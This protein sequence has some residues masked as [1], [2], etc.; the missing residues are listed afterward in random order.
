MAA[1]QASVT[2]LGD[3]LEN[4]M[5]DGVTPEDQMLVALGLGETVFTAEI[6]MENAGFKSTNRFGIY[7]YANPAAKLE[8]FAGADAV[9]DSVTV[10]F[11]AANDQ[12]WID[13]AE[14]MT[15]GTTFG[16]Y[17]DSSAKSQ[18]GVFYSDPMQNTG[19]DQGVVHALFFTPN[20]GELFVAFEDLR[21][22]TDWY[23]QDYNDM[24]VSMN[25]QGGGYVPEPC[26]VLLLGVGSMV[27]IPRRK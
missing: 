16:F 4:S 27:F 3:I 22:N 19:P 5:Y 8:L 7:D 15:M 26:S 2:T 23:D 1:A 13:P 20:L 25:F 18:G 10:Y 17:L 14:K 12:A 9:G 6:R 21:V 24:V 11:D